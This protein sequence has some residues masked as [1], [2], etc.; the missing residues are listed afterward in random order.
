[1]ATH[2]IVLAWRTPGREAWW[3]VVYGVAQSWT[4]LKRL[5]SGVINKKPNLMHC[6]RIRTKLITL[7]IKNPTETHAYIDFLKIW[8]RIKKKTIKNMASAIAHC[9]GKEGLIQ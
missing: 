5:S 8:Q 9:W 7:N 2:S 3:A 4:R 1:M 6:V